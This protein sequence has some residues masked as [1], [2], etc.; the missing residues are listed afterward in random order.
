MPSYSP[1]FSAPFV[2]YTPST[3]NQSFLVPEGFTAVIRQASCSQ[4]IGGFIFYVYIQD[5]EAAPALDLIVLAQ[6]GVANYVEAQGRWVVPGGG[7]ITAALSEL[8]SSCSMYVGGYL[9]RDTL[10]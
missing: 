2:Q 5:S 1:V 4:N 6:E 10:T 8:G 9:L 7:I 3:P